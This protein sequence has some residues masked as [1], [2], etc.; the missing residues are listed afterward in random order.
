SLVCSSFGALPE[1][2]S[3]WGVGGSRPR[4]VRLPVAGLPALV[5]GELASIG[6]GRVGVVTSDARHAEAARLFPGG[7]LDAPVAVLTVGQA[8]GLEFDAVVVVDPAGIMGQSPMGGQDL[9]V[10]V[11]RATRRLTV[12]Y[13]GELP[14]VL[15]GLA[16]EST[17]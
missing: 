6:E 3:W 2:A 12:V 16:S 7:D 5:D 1:R 17:A 11:T 13:E 8:K 10:A 15:S 9:Y 4:A 14:E